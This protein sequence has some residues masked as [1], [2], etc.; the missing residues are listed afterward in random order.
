M[1]GEH[2]IPF[3][4][5]FTKCDKLSATQVKY[6]IE[7]YRRTLAEQWEELP[8]MLASSSSNGRG[9]EEIIAYIESILAEKQTENV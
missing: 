1:L 7:R 9:R 5:I 3:A 2:G 6:S 8:A 4:I